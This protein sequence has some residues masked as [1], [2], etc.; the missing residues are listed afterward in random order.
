MM[1]AACVTPAIAQRAQLEQ[2][3]QRRVLPNGLEVI[4]IENHGVPLVT[5]EVTV[6]N[7]AFTQTPEYAGLAHL[8]EHM[9]FKANATYPEPDEYIDEM[10]R[11]GAVFNASTREEQ[12]NY[13]L[14]LSADSLAA[15]L[16]ML[17]TG[18]IA[19]AFRADELARERQVV[20]GEY[21]RN[22]SSP[23][24]R[25]EQETG[26]L[27]WDSQWSR[28]NVIGDRDVIL[29]T[30]PEKMRTI[31]QLYYVPNNSVLI[32]SG[33]VNP[34]E[35]FPLAEKI[36]GPW[37][38]GEDPFA[39]API[40]AM[41]RLTGTKAVVLEEDVNAVTVIVQWDGPS[42]R[43][44]EAST[45][46]ADVYSDVLNN[47]QSRFQ[48]RLVDSGL[49]QAVGVNYYTLNNVGPISVSG[50]TTPER[51]RDAIRAMYAEL[52]A[53][54]QPGYF[55][56]EELAATKANRAVTTEF[57]MERSSEFS[58]TIGFWWSVSGLD[59]YMKYVD[60]MAKRTADDLRAY[61]RKYIIGRPSVIGV[62][63]SPDDRRRIGLS[64][65]ELILLGAPR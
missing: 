25:L 28:K 47:P 16:R 55:S 48:R 22:E 15:G 23:F 27:L 12:V 9:F 39:K 59:Y 6:R 21:D 2:I 18:F 29:G 3:V 31:Q 58:H 8:Y 61:A 44:D 32:I 17:V 54:V 42:V 5:V 65:R 26:K 30:T 49:W 11:L 43:A 57:G 56:D 7:G 60:E 51:L 34:A 40:P 37:S 46:A 45:F 63:I 53:S 36:F 62:L 20:I 33:D 52:S 35:A 50:Q 1:A 19:P 10:S 24:F 64:E 4:V 14:T 13:Y 41:P 38:R